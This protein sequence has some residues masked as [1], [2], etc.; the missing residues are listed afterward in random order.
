MNKKVYYIA[1]TEYEGCGHRH[2]IIEEAVKCMKRLNR[3]IELFEIYSMVEG[4][5]NNPKV[6]P[7]RRA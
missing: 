5:P 1:A 7:Y 6:K 4:R 3:N 2:Q